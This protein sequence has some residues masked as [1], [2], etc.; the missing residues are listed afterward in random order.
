MIE[1]VVY[2]GSVEPPRV[3][4]G[5]TVK[6]GQTSYCSPTRGEHKSKTGELGEFVFELFIH[7]TD[8]FFI[9]VESSGFMPWEGTLKGMDCLF[10]AC[11]PLEVILERSE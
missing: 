6:L 2:D 3:I 4:E 7:D 11:P 10:C 5:A 8:G 9:L 1:G